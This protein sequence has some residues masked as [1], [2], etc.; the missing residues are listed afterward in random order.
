[1]KKIIRTTKAGKRIIVACYLK[2]KELAETFADMCLLYGASTL[3]IEEIND[4]ERFHH[5]LKP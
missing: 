5:D 2:G 3:Q 1:M 4:L